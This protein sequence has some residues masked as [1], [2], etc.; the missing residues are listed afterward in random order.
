MDALNVGT[1]NGS[2]A[3]QF[4][5]EERIPVVAQDLYDVCP[6]KVYFFPASG[7]ALVKRLGALRSDTL[8]QREREYRA[9]LERGQGGEIEIFGPRR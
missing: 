9:Q 4:L 3:L 1:Q 7:K 8:E 5:A 6:R 2:F